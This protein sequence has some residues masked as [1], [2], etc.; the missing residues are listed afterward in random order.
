MQRRTATKE[1]CK[2]ALR[3]LSDTDW[4][5]LDEMARLRATGLKTVEGRDLLHDAVDRMLGGKRKWPLEVPLIVFLRET[6]RSIASNMWRRQE[7]AV[8]VTESEIRRN[9]EKGEG[10]I[11]MAADTSMAPEARTEAAQTLER[12]EELF[13]DDKD[14]QAVMVGMTSGKSPSEIQEENAMDRV[15][16]ATT[17]RRIRRRLNHFRKKEKEHEQHTERARAS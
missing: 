13:K 10:V 9:P 7:E 2:E 5:R 1:E 4:R 14:A 17:Q 11:A 12:I 16:Y 8:V 15:Q 6:M 3:Q